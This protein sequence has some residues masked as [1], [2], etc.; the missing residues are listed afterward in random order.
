MSKKVAVLGASDKASRYS[1][2]AVDQLASGGY[3]VIPVNTAGKEILGIQSVKTV[4]EIDGSLDTLTIY[5]NPAVTDNLRDDIL[6]LSV[7]RVIFN[8]GAENP[9]LEKALI[10]KGVEAINA[11]TLVM[12]STDQF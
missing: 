12:L 4:N 8:P 9:Q 1:Y 11:C 2:K 5:V 6:N 3:E 10:E 7:K